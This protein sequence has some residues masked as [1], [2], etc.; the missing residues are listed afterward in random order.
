[1]LLPSD[2]VNGGQISQLGHQ[3]RFRGDREWNIK[4][5]SLT[6]LAFVPVDEVPDVYE[7][8]KLAFPED[9]ASDD[10]LEYFELTYIK[11]I[12][13]RGGRLRDP[14]YPVHLRNHF[15]SALIEDPRTTNSAEGS[16]NALRSLLTCSH[17][18][19]WKLFDSLRKDMLMVKLQPRVKPRK[20]NLQ[21]FD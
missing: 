19:V 10:V 3:D 14:M 12:V 16:H 13:L 2:T 15:N 20:K 18:T 4:V 21:S 9:Q 8:L 6:S 1:M 5:R 11:G 7:E 17:P